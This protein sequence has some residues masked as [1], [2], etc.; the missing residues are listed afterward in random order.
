MSVREPSVVEAI[1][2]FRTGLYITYLYI[3]DPLSHFRETFTKFFSFCV[4]ENSGVRSVGSGKSAGG[5]RARGYW[6]PWPRSGSSRQERWRLDAICVNSWVI[7]RVSR[8]LSKTPISFLIPPAHILQSSGPGNFARGVFSEDFIWGVAS[9][10]YQIEGA[11][12]EDG[13]GPNIWDTFTHKP[14]NTYLNQTGDIACDSYHK[15]DEDVELVKDLGVSHYRFSLSWSRLLPK[16][17][18]EFVNP[19]GVKYYNE[20]IDRLL[21]NGIQPAV[22][23]VHFDLPQALQDS[24]GWLNPDI[25]DI[26]D[27]YARFCFKEFGDRVKLWLTINEPHEE[28]LDAYG[29]GVFAPGIRQ[30]A[31][32]P[33]RGRC[34]SSLRRGD[35]GRSYEVIGNMQEFEITWDFHSIWH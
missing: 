24:G 19:K 22:T 29:L 16:G 27:Q 34:L 4:T 28:A 15:L 35:G 11:W 20:L 6:S 30:L 8:V 12:D 25:A 5:G 13:K 31:A 33:Y 23:L 7:C 26:F 2:I 21:A 17:T 32:G 1:R 9:A 14:G 3:S 10:A 18:V